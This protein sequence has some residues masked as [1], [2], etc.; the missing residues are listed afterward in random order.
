M[1]WIGCCC[2]PY[3][4]VGYCFFRSVLYRVAWRAR[5]M[6][7]VGC[8]SFPC[9]GVGYCL[10]RSVPLFYPRITATDRAAYWPISIWRNTLVICP[11][12]CLFCQVFIRVSERG[13]EQ[14]C[15][16]RAVALPMRREADGE[17]NCESMVSSSRS[18][19]SPTRKQRRCLQPK[20]D[21]YADEASGPHR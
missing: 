2:F 13:Y 5:R 3:R 15:F 9:R 10:F 6:P 17:G 14:R 21:T 7:W 1:P 19:S 12:P 8:C 11:K 4:G 18:G 16:G 20:D